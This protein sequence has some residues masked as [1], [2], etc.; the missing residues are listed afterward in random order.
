MTIDIPNIDY[1]VIIAKIERM[2][3][4]I[5]YDNSDFICSTCFLTKDMLIDLAEYILGEKAQKAGYDIAERLNTYFN[6]IVKEAES[7]D[8]DEI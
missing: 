5:A 7:E 6:D 3:F 1:N 4:R 8:D 2:L